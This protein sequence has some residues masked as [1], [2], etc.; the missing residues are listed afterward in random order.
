MMFSLQQI[1]T[2]NIMEVSSISFIPQYQWSTTQ[3]PNKTFIHYAT[4][5]IF[6]QPF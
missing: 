4:P 6:T 3:A 2:S 5:I 1:H